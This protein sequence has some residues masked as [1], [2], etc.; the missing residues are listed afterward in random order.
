M[1]A[2]GVKGS[3]I[4]RLRRACGA[5][6]VF[7][8]LALVPLQRAI[9]RELAARGNVGELLYLPSGWALQRLSLGH[10]GLLAD[11]YWTRVVQYF[12]RK[13]LSGATRFDLLGPL[14][15]ITTELDPQ[16]VIAYRFGAIFLA[17]KAPAGAGQPE[18]ALQLL[19]RGIVANPDYWRLWQDLGFIYYWDLKDYESAARV[20]RVGSE[21]PGA[22]L[23]MKAMAASVAAEGGAAQTSRLLW[24]EIYRQADND[25]IRT[26]A[27]NHL[28]ALQAQEEI[29]SLNA[30][31]TEYRQAVGRP[32]HSF[33]EL[34]AAGLLRA[35]PRDPSGAPYQVGP[36]GLTT[37]AP[38]SKI[39]LRLVR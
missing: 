35:R 21:R 13:R 38:G 7:S 25:Q 28:R 20:F 19:R 36:G 30:L 23:W 37:L 29:E 1:T 3:R 12:G 39:D 14:L 15:R 4:G 32:A 11:F 22:Q 33:R 26:S 17:E 2:A 8:F 10:E 27:E 31:L 9:D 34:V 5:V 18:E 24:S 16:L 6:L